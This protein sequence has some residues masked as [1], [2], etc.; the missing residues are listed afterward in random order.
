[1]STPFVGQIQ[2]F[3]Y[4]FAPRGWAQCNGQ[5]MPINQY[6]A[7]FSVLGTSFGGNG[8]QTF[9]LP[10]LQG[11]FMLGHG[12]GF[13]L[14]QTGGQS[15]VLL[16]VNQIPAHTHTLVAS[17][18]DAKLASPIGAFPA[19]YSTA[20]LYTTPSNT[21]MGT[22]SSPAGGVPH[23]NMPPYLVLNVCIALEGIFPSRN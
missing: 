2:V 7:L 15:S 13:A 17:S 14:G 1:M 23:E 3:P 10:N 12:G 5:M 6:Q 11:Q 19:A 4:N 20:K 18:G 9:A 8:T 22:G 16:T 21:T